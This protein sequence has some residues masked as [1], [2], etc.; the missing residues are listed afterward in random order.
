[1]TTN[2]FRHS[3][4][5]PVSGYRVRYTILDG[6][7]AVFVPS[8]QRFAEG[9]S[10][11]NGDASVTLMQTEPRPGVNRIGIEIIRP[12]DAPTGAGLIIFRGETFKEWVASSLGITKVGPPTAAVGQ[13]FNYVITVTNTGKVP[14][15]G[16]VVRDV[17]GEGLTYV[18]AQP[19]ATVEGNNLVWNLG[20]VEPG[21][22]AAITAQFRPERLGTMTNVANVTSADGGRTET[23]ATT[24][25]TA[26][27]LAV[28]IQAPAAGV[29]NQPITY[30]ITVTNTGRGPATNVLL[31]AEFDPALQHATGENRLELALD[32][33][34]AGQSAAR[35]LVLTARQAGQ[36]VTRAIATADGNLRAADEKLVTITQPRLS[37]R[38]AGPPYKY[39][40]RPAEWTITIV[41]DGDVPASNVFVRNQLPGD[42]LF[43]AASEGGQHVGGGQIVWN[44]GT[45]QPREERRLTFSAQAEQVTPRTV[46][47]ATLT[48]DPGLTERAES[49]I[50]IRGA[51]GLSLKVLDTRDPLELGDTTTYVV[52]VVNTGQLT[53]DAVAISGTV[54]EELQLVSGV[55][56]QNAQARIQ[57]NAITFQPIDGLAPGQTF[58]FEVTAKAV[59]VGDSRFRLQLKSTALGPDPV[60]REES[61]NVFRP[62]ENGPALPPVPATPPPP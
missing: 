25:V 55:G 19:P 33:L 13:P 48:A 57:G 15:E 24:Q 45:L 4:R 37:L 8:Q 2:V 28:A 23:A 26:P 14:A 7:P 52:D 59:K 49:A 60:N 21:R 62:I 39:V 43:V 36:F 51:P 10:N 22:S 41:N 30:Q 61:T 40:R 12:P 54:T 46:T 35:N 3:D 1:M 32:A 17:A 18:N 11:V 53:A 50:E 34:G 42:L 5:A 44:L 58:R 31:T 20:T 56:P 6:P 29:V 9:I 16:V 27:G 47:V 38:M